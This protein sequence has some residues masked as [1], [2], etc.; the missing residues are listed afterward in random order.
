MASGRARALLIRG[1]SQGLKPGFG[2]SERPKAEALGYLGANA[3]SSAI[4]AGRNRWA[5]ESICMME[6][7]C[8]AERAAK[9]VC[10]RHR[11]SLGAR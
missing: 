7:I 4:Y 2:L 11:H 1:I 10:K 3:A 5:A 6:R 9:K 8:M